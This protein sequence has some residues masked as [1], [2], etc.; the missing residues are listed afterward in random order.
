MVRV[1]AKVTIARREDVWNLILTGH[2]PQQIIKIL[3]TT[4]AV[5]YKDLNFLTEESKKFMYSIAKGTHVLMYRKAIDG[6]NLALAVAW[7]KVNDSKT[8]EKTRLGYLRL[9]GEFYKSI[10]Q[11]TTDGPCIM[12]LEDITRRAERLGINID[13][14]SPDDK[15]IK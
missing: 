1:P 4:Q 10:T 13:A 7:S 6:T 5:I 8:P 15:I 12:A 11:L 3:G 9:I 14:G 2:T